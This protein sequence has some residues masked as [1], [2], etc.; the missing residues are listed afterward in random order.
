MR[1]A[2][3]LT[4]I[5]TRPEY[6]AHGLQVHPV[7]Y[8]SHE[9]LGY[10]LQGVDLVISTISGPEQINL[11]LAAGDG[12]VRHFVPAEFEGSLS[13]RRPHDPLDQSSTQA[14]DLMRHLDQ[15]RRMRFTVFSCGVLMETFLPHGL[16]T[17]GIGYGTGVANAGDYLAN[18]N[19]RTAEYPEHNSNG[20]QIRICL[21]SACDLVRFMIAAIDLCPSTWPREF[22]LRGDRMTLRQVVDSCSMGLNGKSEAKA[23]PTADLYEMVNMRGTSR[24][25]PSDAAVQRTRHVLQPLHTDRR[26]L[27]C[28]L[29]PAHAGHSGWTV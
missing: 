23:Q 14:L 9:S 18:T 1:P 16:G 10:A 26:L 24:V 25:Q 11:I 15:R 8:Y 22:T 3:L 13:H 29:L 21:T 7:N 20:E 17:L 5:K 27:P 12:R 4:H 28:G 6:A 19:A 2:S